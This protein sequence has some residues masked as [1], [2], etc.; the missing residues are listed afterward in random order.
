MERMRQYGTEAEMAF[1][2]VG[3]Y[4]SWLPADPQNP[5]V[6]VQTMLMVSGGTRCMG[7]RHPN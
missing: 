4:G 5:T 3:I 6:P 7:G 1:G 2:L